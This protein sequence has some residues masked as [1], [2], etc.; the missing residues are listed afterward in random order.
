MRNIP[1]AFTVLELCGASLFTI[2]FNIM[3]ALDVRLSRRALFGYLKQC[4]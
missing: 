3:Q 1:S 2:P 4:G